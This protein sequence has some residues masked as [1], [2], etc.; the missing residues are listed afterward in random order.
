MR[1]SDVAELLGGLFAGS[2]FLVMM[3]IMAVVFLVAVFFFLLRAFSLYR[4]AERRGITHPWLAWIPYAQEYLYAEIIGTELKIGT[5][6]VPQ[7]PW[8]YIAIVYGS[9]IV[10]LALAAIPVLGAIIRIPLALAIYVACIY[11]MYRFFKIFKGDNA[12]VFTVIC[13]I[14]PIASPFILLYLRN[15]EFAEEKVEELQVITNT[16]V[17]NP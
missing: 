10:S 11:V 17:P 14:L 16:D 7:F 1:D 6:T 9:S 15:A 4:I 2:F 12:V 8:V 5:K 13:A 3:I